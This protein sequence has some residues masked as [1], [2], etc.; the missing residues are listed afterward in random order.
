MQYY[1][2]IKKNENFAICSNMNGPWGHYAKLNKA[3]RERQ[4]PY[5]FTYT[6]NLKTNKL[7][8]SKQ[9]KHTKKPSS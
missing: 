9:N 6:W 2:A 3:D 8:K 1:L 7:I 4:M 5:D